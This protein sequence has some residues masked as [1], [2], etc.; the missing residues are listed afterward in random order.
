MY[1]LS[2]VHKQP[3]KLS[4]ARRRKGSVLLAKIRVA[5]LFGGVSSE[6]EVS[7]ISAAAVADSLDPDKYEVLKIGITK[8]GRWLLYPGPTD[9]MQDGSWERFPDCAPAFISPDRPTRGIVYNHN[10]VFDTLKLDVIFPVLHGRNGEDGTVQ[11]LFELSGIPYVGC[12]ILASAMCMDKSVTNQVFDT[13]GIPHT[14][15][16]AMHRDETGDMDEVLRRVGEKLAYPVF[17][18]PAVG[19]SSVGVTKVKR[20]EDLHKAVLLA[21]AHDQKILFEQGV[22]GKEVESAVLGNRDPFATLPGEIEPCNEIY[23]YEA[24]YQSGDASKL[25]LPARLPQ[26][27][28]EEVR[29]LAVQAFC[30][31]NCSG[32]A[33]VDFFVEEGTERVLINEINTL[34][35]F[36]SISMYAKL[37]EMSGVSFTELLDKLITLAFERAEG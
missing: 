37:M 22:T 19:G 26:Q 36:T 18:K 16:L 13:V 11:G 14:P 1:F 3:G 2:V 31:L 23:D 24:K 29:Q 27:K 35:G 5:V 25:H 7:R 28:L 32:L 10:G 34:P 8:K 12:G 21:T 9:K 6:H 17:V 30:A 15:W 4:A 20:P 33:R